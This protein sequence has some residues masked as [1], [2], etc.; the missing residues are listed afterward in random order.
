MQI[1]YLIKVFTTVCNAIVRSGS[2]YYYLLL[3]GILCT[4]C[5]WR[6]TDAEAIFFYSCLHG[7]TQK[8]VGWLTIWQERHSKKGTKARFPPES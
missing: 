6:G 3:L 1:Q 5:C 2:C 8:S 4:D 7:A